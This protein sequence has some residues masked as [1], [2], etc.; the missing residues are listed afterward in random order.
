MLT[1]LLFGDLCEVLLQRASWLRIK[2]LFDGYEGWVDQKM[3]LPLSA[4]EAS[5][6]RGHHFVLQGELILE[7]QSRMPL[8]KGAR[9][10]LLAQ[11]AIPVPPLKIGSKTWH[12]DSSLRHT[13]PLSPEQ[14]VSLAREFL[15]T[16]YLWGGCSSYGID[17]SG[18]TQVVFRMCG[19]DLPRDSSQQALVGEEVPFGAHQA[20][21]LAFFAKPDQ[22]KITHVGLISGPETI[23]H[24][25]GK[26]REDSFRQTGILHTP[27]LAITHQLITIKR[28]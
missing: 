24:A 12:W 20:G 21:D 1:Q 2:H 27:S 14:R 18:F 13:A 5:D 7:D 15:N 16:S 23:L 6:I 25:S 9:L 22:Q 3:L 17:C 11:A 28:C 26:V 8:P 4:R 19:M 10:P